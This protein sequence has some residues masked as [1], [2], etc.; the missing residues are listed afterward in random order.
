MREPL[1]D[2][3]RLEHI[4]NSI[5]AVQEF[6]TAKDPEDLKNDRLLLFGVV[7]GLEIIGEAAYKITN[8]FKGNHPATPWGM[9]IGLRHVLVHGYYQVRPEEICLI[10]KND[11]PILKPQIEGY[12]KE[13]DM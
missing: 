11:L 4:L 10:V 5:N 1:R 2:P 9:I 8:E 12:L 13:I 3:A 7:K 6:M